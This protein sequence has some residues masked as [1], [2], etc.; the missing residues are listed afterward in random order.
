MAGSSKPFADPMNSV[1]ASLTTAANLP[2]HQD[3]LLPT[4]TQHA[5]TSCVHRHTQIAHKH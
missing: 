4:T 1:L 3:M 5:H 2:V